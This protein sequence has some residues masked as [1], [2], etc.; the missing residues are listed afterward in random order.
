MPFYCLYSMCHTLVL[1]T[2]YALHV[3][4]VHTSRDTSGSSAILLWFLKRALLW[5][6][7]VKKGSVPYLDLKCKTRAWESTKKCQKACSF[8]GS[9]ILFDPCKYELIYCH[10]QCAM[11]LWT[12][13]TGQDAVHWSCWSHT[14]F[15]ATAYC[16]SV[17]GGTS[18]L[19]ASVSR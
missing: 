8:V 7:T 3:L 15:M 18:G 14:G 11:S 4:W 19:S 10:Q 13:K 2:I 17:S 1:Q 16:H 6:P 12:L 9:T 5:T